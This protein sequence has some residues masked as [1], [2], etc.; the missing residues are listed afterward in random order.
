MGSVIKFMTGGDI[1]AYRFRNIEKLIGSFVVI[2]LLLLI[3]AIILIARG[4]HLMTKK[5]YYTTRF[6][7]AENLSEGMPVKFKGLKIGAVKEIYLDEKNQIIVKFYVL[8]EYASKIK[9]D[10][11]LM[12]NSPLI[13]EK[14]LEITAGMPD[15]P[16]AREGDFLYST[17][18]EEGRKYLRKQLAQMPATPTDLILKNVQ[19]LTAQLS[20]P[21]GAF[22]QTLQNFRR[23][24]ESLAQ[25]KDV[26]R[27]TMEALK[28]SAKNMKQLTENLKRNPLLGGWGSKSRKK[29][30]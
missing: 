10:S 6:I 17:D 12:I 1:M 11:V 21:N 16:V 3:A 5:F 25:N 9:K 26:I 7:S 15:S 30:K 4:Q 2:S 18:I 14:F 13:G 20:D 29:K 27:E 28:D 22:M 24:S 19:L 8:K 23:L